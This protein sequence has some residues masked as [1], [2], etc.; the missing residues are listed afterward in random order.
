MDR[1]RVEGD[2][3]NERTVVRSNCSGG[4]LLS[5]QTVIVTR[6]YHLN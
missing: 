5:V 6:S 4:G 3:L 2:E 1:R